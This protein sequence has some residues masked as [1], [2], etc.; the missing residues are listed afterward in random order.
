M[1]LEKDHSILSCLSLERLRLLGRSVVSAPLTNSVWQIG[2]STGESINERVF[3]FV[4]TL[5]WE[6]HFCFLVFDC[7][8]WY[9]GGLALDSIRLCFSLTFPE[10]RTLWV[11]HSASLDAL[12]PF[13]QSGDAPVTTGCLRLP[14]KFRKIPFFALIAF[15]LWFFLVFS[16]Q[17]L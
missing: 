9:L 13:A 5:L 16:A 10:G 15:R 6:N 17:I 14:V 11:L 7:E 3:S 2:D 1:Y 12:L 8:N 4:W